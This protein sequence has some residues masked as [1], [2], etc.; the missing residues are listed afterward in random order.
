MTGLNEAQRAAWERDGYLVLPGFVSAAACDALR[1]RMDELLDAFDPAGVT[2]VFRTDDQAHGRDRYFLESGATIRF[3]FEPDAFDARGELRQAKAL[4]INKVGHAL[5]DLDPVFER[6]SRSPELAAVARDA[7][8]ADP[9]LLQ[10]MYIFKQPRIGGEVHC[11]QDSTFL[12]TEPLTCT[13]F[14]FALEDATLENGCM[15]A[16]PGGHRRPLASRF[17]REGSG[18]RMVTLDPA[19]LPTDGLVPL[20]ATKGS[21]VL[22]HGQLPHRSGANHSD[23]S[24]HAYALHLVD[25]TAHYSPDNWLVRPETMPLRGFA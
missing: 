18:T 10:S 4:S 16:E 5:H 6:F 8:L 2:T 13:G 23:R 9:R 11:H 21:L 12:H 7:G 20:E 19:P 1:R 14:W 15:W 24:R 17:V 22:L 3:F 25:G